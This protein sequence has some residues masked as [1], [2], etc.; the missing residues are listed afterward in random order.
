[1]RG[2]RDVPHLTAPPPPEHLAGFPR[3]TYPAG[4]SLFR[5]HLIERDPWWFASSGEGR[6]DLAA[7]HG[8]CYVAEDP[9][10]TLLEVWGGLRVIP[11]PYARARAVPPSCCPSRATWLT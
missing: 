6:F 3:R 8:T 10:L 5:A 11:M 2:G 7:P 4:R 1:M 9:V